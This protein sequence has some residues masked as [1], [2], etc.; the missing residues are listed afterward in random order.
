MNEEEITEA[1]N[2]MSEQELNEYVF[3]V[4][5]ALKEMTKMYEIAQVE[6]EKKDLLINILAE[7]L[8]TPIHSKEWI[9]DYYKKEI[10]K[11]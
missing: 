11:C 7:Q 5:F 10:E 2:N 1:I 8:T 3:F 6:I 9:I 4:F